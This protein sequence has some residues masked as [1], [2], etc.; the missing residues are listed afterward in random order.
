MIYAFLGVARID[1]GITVDY[2]QTYGQILVHAAQ[3]IIQTDK[4]LAL[5]IEV[6]VRK[7]TN[8]GAIGVYRY[9]R[10]DDWQIRQRLKAV[11]N[12]P[13]WVPDWSIPPTNEAA[14]HFLGHPFSMEVDWGMKPLPDA[15]T[16]SGQDFEPKFL[17]VG[18]GLP[19]CGLKIGG[20]L[21]CTLERFA[22]D[23]TFNLFSATRWKGLVEG[24]HALEENYITVESTAEAT[25]RD[26]SRPLRIRLTGQ[27]EPLE[28]WLHLHQ[29]HRA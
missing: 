15:W 25:T 19:V 3:R 21:I 1:C 9:P 27:L 14:L 8:S 22:D 26:Q 18:P 2:S 6:T 29:W 17:H 4:N 5:L 16:Q 24:S 20:E 12:L 28:A 11:Q 7:F 13:S 10:S 23:S